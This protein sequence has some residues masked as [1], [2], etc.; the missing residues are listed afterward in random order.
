MTGGSGKANNE[1]IQNGD[2]LRGESL[3]FQASEA[4]QLI[5]IQTES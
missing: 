5:V 4:S 3:E 2:L 1:N